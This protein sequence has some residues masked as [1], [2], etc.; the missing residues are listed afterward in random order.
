M[1]TEEG[2]GRC[3]S[4]S[5]KDKEVRT[6]LTKESRA[7]TRTRG[8]EDREVRTSAEEAGREVP[9]AEGVEQVTTTTE[10][11]TRETTEEVAQGQEMAKERDQSNNNP[12]EERNQEGSTDEEDGSAPRESGIPASQGDTESTVKEESTEDGWSTVPRQRSA[13]GPRNGGHDSTLGTQSIFFPEWFDLSEQD[14]ID[15]YGPIPATRGSTPV[16]GSPKGTDSGSVT[17]P[18]HTPVDYS[19]FG[20]LISLFSDNEGDET[21]LY[22][23]SPAY[24]SEDEQEQVRTAIEQ[25]IRD[26]IEE[27]D[28]YE[29]SCGQ[30]EISVNAVRI[31]TETE[32]ANTYSGK[33]KGVDRDDK[34]KEFLRRYCQGNSQP[35][36]ASS[37]KVKVEDEHATTRSPMPL[38]R[39]TPDDLPETPPRTPSPRPK[40]SKHHH[41]EKKRGKSHRTIREDSQ[42]PDGGFFSKKVFGGGRGNIG[43][44]PSPSDS[45]PDGSDSDSGESDSGRSSTSSSTGRGPNG[46][47]HRSPSRRNYRCRHRS[48]DRRLHRAISGI[49]LKSPFVWDGK[50]DLDVFDHWI[51][52]VE[53]WRDLHGL[54]DG[55][56]LKIIVNFLSGKPS[57][58]FMQHVAM[59]QHEWDLPSLYEALYVYCFPIDFKRKLRERFDGIQQGKSQRVRDFMRE[60]EQL[61][62]RL[63]DISARQIVQA[64]WKGMHQYLR[65][66][67]IE[68][69]LDPESTRLDR[70]VRYAQRR[71][72]AHYAQLREEREFEGRVPGRTWGRFKNCVNRPKPYSPERE[73][74]KVPVEAKSV[75]VGKT[76]GSKNVPRKA[77]GSSSS[78]PSHPKRQDRMRSPPSRRTL[79]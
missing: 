30:S 44:S 25:S 77:T 31:Q 23:Y 64:F 51:Y 13:S 73:P 5:D 52:E 26:R 6:R 39:K 16:E 53:T 35:A 42:V 29:E 43:Q 12:E 4:T 24:N 76:K 60:I 74:K 41:T 49:K 1:R 20:E 15:P 58:Y 54:D 34:Q 14:D 32:E 62:S 21:T 59:N 50:A 66:Y 69:G 71:E 10:E 79:L 9:T 28:G 48:R 17:L 7:A 55:L 47:R 37:S 63:S 27:L 22:E 11:V 75:N 36:E 65:L 56:T 78:Q 70:L 38:R 8:H 61:A 46:G 72:E 57:K 68:Q 3:Q 33:G 18:T 67:L 19:S 2:Q 40:K 45:D